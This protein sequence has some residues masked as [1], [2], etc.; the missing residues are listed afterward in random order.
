MIRRYTI[1]DGK[2]QENGAGDAPVLVYAGPTDEEKKQLVEVFKIDEHTL[3]SALDPDELGRL[4]FEEDHVAIIFKRPKNYSSADNFLFKVWSY[5]LFLFP[6]RIIVVRN[7][8]I[9]VFD[10]RH[11]AK[12]RTPLDV[13]LRLLSRTINHFIDHIKGIN[14][15]AGELEQKISSSM[16][17]RYL[18]NMFTIEKSLVYYLYGINSNGVVIDKLKISASKVGFTPENIEYLDDLIIENNQCYRQAEVLSGILSSLMDAR[19]SIVSNNLNMTIRRLTLI[20]TIF[21]PLSF[22]AG[23]GGMSEWSMITGPRNWWISYPVFM[24]LMGGLGL[25]IYFVL[26]RFEERDRSPK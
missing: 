6:N 14:L 17:N 16:E 18:L 19:A 7:E 10:T 13:A 9:P 25:A 5:G 24:L 22:L 12:L 4:E 1:T 3:A 23:V 26:K 11:F 2:L 15:I 20:S 21:L 8:D